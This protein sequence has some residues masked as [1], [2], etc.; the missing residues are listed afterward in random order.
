MIW[1]SHGMSKM[2]LRPFL[3]CLIFL[4]FDHN[5]GYQLKTIILVRRIMWDLWAAAG[6]ISARCSHCPVLRPELSVFPGPPSVWGLP[7]TRKSSV[8]AQPAFS[9]AQKFSE[10]NHAMPGCYLT[11]FQDHLP[12]HAPSWNMVEI[13]RV[14]P[15]LR[16]GL[17][18]QSRQVK[19]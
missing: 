15:P 1:P 2:E 10:L 4:V 12:V 14:D 8:S 17:G 3:I 11:A 19:L 5:I 9:P 7:G 6:D 18:I 16:Q 13:C